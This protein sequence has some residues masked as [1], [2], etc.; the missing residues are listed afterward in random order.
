MISSVPYVPPDTMKNVAATSGQSVSLAT[1]FFT[2]GI[3]R[4]G[5]WEGTDIEL[6]F[7]SRTPKRKLALAAAVK[8][9]RIRRIQQAPPHA[10]KK[11]TQAQFFS[12]WPTVIHPH[13]TST[14]NSVCTTTN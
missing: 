14:G 13:T 2:L 6:N 8:R 12:V 3:T 4:E 11:C 1:L 7:Y 10:R 5:S 9:V